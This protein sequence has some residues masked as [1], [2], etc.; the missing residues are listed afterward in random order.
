MPWRLGW[1]VA[2]EAVERHDRADAAADRFPARD[3]VGARG[4]FLKLPDLVGHSGGELRAPAGPW[5]RLVVQE[6]QGAGGVALETAG[7]VVWVEVQH[8]PFVAEAD[9]EV[10]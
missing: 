4:A 5:E 10:L 9:S 1:P 6:Q 8:D 2:A 7:V 3:T